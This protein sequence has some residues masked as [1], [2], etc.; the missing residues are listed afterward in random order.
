MTDVTY[1]VESGGGVDPD[2]GDYT[3][4]TVSDTSVRVLMTSYS[5]KELWSMQGYEQGDMKAL[6]ERTSSG[7]TPSVDGKIVDGSGNEWEIVD[8]RS[9]PV[10]VLWI[11]QLRRLT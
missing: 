8:I 7:I 4:P 9:D 10:E 6:M 2:T 3:E 5:W 1:R 11:M